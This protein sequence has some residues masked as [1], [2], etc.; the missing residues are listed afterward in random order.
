MKQIAAIGAQQAGVNANQYM[1]PVARAE[2]NERSQVVLLQPRLAT[3]Q[4][5]P[6]R[7]ILS[8][9][10]QGRPELDGVATPPNH[11]TPGGSHQV[12]SQASQGRCV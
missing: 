7:R 5:R 1:A 11:P 8:R 9:L 6:P 4:H 10:G 12:G 2:M 3:D